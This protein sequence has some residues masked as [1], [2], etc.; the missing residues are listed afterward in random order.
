[1]KEAEG[2]SR[3]NGG[4]VRTEGEDQGYMDMYAVYAV[5]VDAVDVD[6]VDVDAVDVD[7]VG[8]DDGR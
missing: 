5:D 3:G 7:A 8:V 4:R 1:M 2:T 6:A